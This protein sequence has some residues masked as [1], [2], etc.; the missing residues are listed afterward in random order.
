MF[1]LSYVLPPVSGAAFGKST[2]QEFAHPARA[3]AATRDLLI[4]KGVDEREATRFSLTL[5]RK[6]TGTGWVN[7]ETGITFRIDPEDRAPNVCPCCGRLVKWGDH[8]LAGS[9]DAYCLGCYTWDRNSNP[10]LPENT[11]HATDEEN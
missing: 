9:D 8:A 7:T 4:S 1:V 2:V 11:A 3:A 5:A 10:C 6:G